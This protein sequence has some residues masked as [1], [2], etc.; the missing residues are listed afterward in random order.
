MFKKLRERLRRRPLDPGDL[1]SED[2]R[3]VDNVDALP[4]TDP[5]A[6]DAYELLGTVPPGYVKAYDDGRP[7]H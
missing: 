5:R 7:Q 6:H 4:A 2:G 3:P 1:M